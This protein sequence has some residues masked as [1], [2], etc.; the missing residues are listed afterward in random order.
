MPP[1]T[2]RQKL[3]ARLLS[4]AA[5]VLLTITSIL[6]A[7]L[8]LEVFLQITYRGGRFRGNPWY[9][10]GS[11]PRYLVMP[12]AS[13]GYKLRPNFHGMEI[14]IWGDF[15]VPVNINSL[16]MR[17]REHRLDA[18]QTCILLVGD[19]F[20][21]GEGVHLEESFL[22]RAEQM[23]QRE[24]LGLS[25]EIYKAGVPAYSLRQEYL[26]VV[27]FCQI[28]TPDWVII[29]LY[30]ERLERLVDNYTYHHGYI[31]KKSYV[32][33][34]YE[35]G[36]NLYESSYQ[37]EPRRQAHLFLQA[38]VYSFNFL[39]YRFPNLGRELKLRYGDQHPG[40]L[41]RKVEKPMEEHGQSDWTEVDSACKILNDFLGLAQQKEFKIF[42]LLYEG[43]PWKDDRIE[44]Y[45]NQNRIPY[46]NVAP[47]INA[48]KARGE[49]AKFP[50]D[51]HWNARG[52]EIVAAVLVKTLL[53]ELRNE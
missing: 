12:D 7:V 14:S 51:G 23:L 37:W 50:R 45:C 18:P 36:G 24:E 6:V 43:E 46:V 52:H 16:G 34:L 29:A 15:A 31:I 8:L 44:A 11:H 49:A 40:L 53:V 41:G 32:S 22:W 5:N 9:A 26:A 4:A 21:Y 25:L 3:A 39:K 10:G 48:A 28:K 20:A 47:S 2:H 1:P 42:V 19:S 30:S 27:D 13:R 17:D 35:I 38:Y 33:K